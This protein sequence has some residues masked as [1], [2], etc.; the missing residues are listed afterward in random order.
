M[1]HRVADAH[2]AR[3]R[4]ARPSA[5]T[6]RCPSPSGRAGPAR[7]RRRSSSPRRRHATARRS[8]RCSRRRSP[9]FSGCTHGSC[10]RAAARIRSPA[11][12]SSR[13]SLGSIAKPS[14]CASAIAYH[15]PPNATSTAIV[16]SPSTSSGA[17][18]RSAKHG[19]FVSSTLS[20]LA[21]AARRAR[22][23]DAAGRLEPERPS[24][25][26]ASRPSRSPAAPSRADRVRARHRRI[27]G[28]LHD[29][30][31]R[32]RSPS[33]VAGTT[34]FAWHGDAPARLAEEQ[35]AQPVVAPERL[36]LLEDG[37][38]RGRQHAADDD[39]P[40]LAAGVAADDGDRAARSHRVSW[41]WTR[42]GTGGTV[43]HIKPLSRPPQ[44][45][46]AE[47]V[48]RRRDREQRRRVEAAVER[49]DPEARPPRSRPRCSRVVR[50]P[51]RAR[52]EKSALPP[53][54]AR[55]RRSAA[56]ARAPRS[57]ARRRARAPAGARA[58][59]PRDRARCRGRPSRPRRRRC[60][61]RRAAR[62]RPR[63]RR[64]RSGTGAAAARSAAAARAV[65]SGST[66]ST[67]RHADG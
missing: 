62:R 49:D 31:A 18:S 47:H 42:R 20:H 12:D 67:A 35:P 64:R 36:H 23:D 50:Q 9:S 14:A 34:R 66:A 51:P 27:L 56:S 41:R 24:P 11:S 6:G 40:D 3:G 37:R 26:R 48:G 28:R 25:A 33:R 65:G 29:D 2:R 45:G 19:T 22:L 43:S 7:R 10:S 30:E 55:G 60:R 16:P 52:V 21:V 17:S 46:D 15:M 54:A 44:A 58:A 38:S 59:P 5:P 63:R 39:V 53:A 57:E 13:A 4:G 61:P 32:R 8:A 1:R